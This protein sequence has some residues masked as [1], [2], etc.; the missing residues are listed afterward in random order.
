M[1]TLV[2]GDLHGQHEIVDGVLSSGLPVI[3]VGDYLDSYTRSRAEQKFTLVKVLDA[4][5]SGQASALRGNHEMS[6]LRQ[7]MR[8]SGYGSTLSFLMRVLEKPRIDTKLVDYLY[9]EGFLITHAGVSQTLLESRQQSLEEYLGGGDYSQIGRVRGG[10]DPV[11]G[12]WWCDFNFEFEPIE[13]VPQIF[14]HTTGHGIRQM[15]NSYCIDCLESDDRQILSIDDGRVEYVI[16][17]SNNKPI[18]E[19]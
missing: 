9:A 12:L 8:C 5:E 2:V 7:D 18:L 11:G 17:D 16:L 4:V 6:Y 3:F 19:N 13:G 15:G 1:K 14:G 10:H